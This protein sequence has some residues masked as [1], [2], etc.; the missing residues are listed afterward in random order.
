[1]QVEVGHRSVPGQT[2]TRAGLRPA[3]RGPSG[4][5]PAGAGRLV[6]GSPGCEPG[7]RGTSLPG[8]LLGVRGRSVGA[9][10]ATLDGRATGLKA[11][12]PVFLDFLRFRRGANPGPP[13][14]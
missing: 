14:G 4:V 9:R 7:G 6:S 5:R 10:Y 13:S 12:P 2:V 3:R 8:L 1:M 11:G